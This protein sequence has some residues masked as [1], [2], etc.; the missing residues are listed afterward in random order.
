MNLFNAIQKVLWLSFLALN[1]WSTGPQPFIIFLQ[2]IYCIEKQCPSGSYFP[3]FLKWFLYLV[4]ASAFIFT[5]AS[6]F[7]VHKVLKLS[8]SLI[9]GPIADPHHTRDEI[10]IVT[11]LMCASAPKTLIGGPSVSDHSCTQLSQVLLLGVRVWDGDWSTGKVQGSTLG[12]SSGGNMRLD[13]GR[14]WACE[15]VTRKGMRKSSQKLWW[16]YSFPRLGEGD[17]NFISHVYQSSYV[18]APGKGSV[19]YHQWWIVSGGFPV[20]SHQ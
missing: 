4:A 9:P 13:W 6:Q 8:C 18:G 1:C 15:A 3:I 20:I 5:V 10:L 12:T 14:I 7:I 19:I 2:N 17:Q 16:S 11:L